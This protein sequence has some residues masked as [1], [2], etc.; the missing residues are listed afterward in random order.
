MPPASGPSA[1][2][3]PAAAPQFSPAHLRPAP[4]GTAEVAGL[5]PAAGAPACPALRGA[6]AHD[7]GPAPRETVE[8]P[9][10]QDTPVL[11]RP[12]RAPNV[13]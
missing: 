7:E 8:R 10:R 6:V 9:S 13:P 1:G 11:H 5:P 2:V 4:T 3:P 12:A